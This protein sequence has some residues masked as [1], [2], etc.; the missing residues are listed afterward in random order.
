[1]N[2]PL[3]R[4]GLSRWL[5]IATLGLLASTAAHAQLTGT[6]AIPTDYATVAAAITALNAQGVGAGGVTFTVPAGYTETFASPTAGAITATGTAANPIVFQKSGAG[7]NP[8]ITAGVGTASLDAIISL[9]GSDYVTLDG[10][11]L[12]ENAANTTTATQ[13]EFGIALFRSSPTDGC[14]FN[15]IRNCVVTLNKANTTTFGIYGAAS[16]A[17]LSTSVAATAPSGANSNNK[18]DGNII[19][20]SATGMYFTASTST[21]I[22]NYDVSNEIGVVAPN[23][24]YNFGTTATGWG[25]GGNY[26]SA[27]KVVNNVVN[28]TLNY[29]GGTT[30]A[31]AASTVTSTLR[32]IYGNACSLGQP[33]HHGQYRDAGQRRHY[34]AD[35]RHRQRHWQHA[36]FEHGKYHGQLRDDDLRHGDHGHRV[37]YSEHRHGRHRHP[38]QQ[39]HHQQLG[40]GYLGHVLG[41]AQHRRRGYADD[42]QQRHHQQHSHGLG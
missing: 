4:T 36:G 3:L 10:L 14:Q 20:N 5:G 2:L 18:V 32:G 41:P 16:T 30:S 42:E 26:Q 23:M 35:D 13:M 7:A 38:E 1:M 22:A 21:T 8:V 37:W 39:H 6:K 27:F 29:A 17:A 33:R 40:D 31:V 15:T 9:S 19:T 12:A 24:V 34:F 25:I 11:S 28:N